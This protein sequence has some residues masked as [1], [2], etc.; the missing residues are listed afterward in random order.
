[1]YPGTCGQELPQGL[2]PGVE[3]L[4]VFSC[5][6]QCQVVFQSNCASLHFYPHQRELLLLHIYASTAI[7]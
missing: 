3:M 4:C 2:Y 5:S 6:R 1:M 7:D